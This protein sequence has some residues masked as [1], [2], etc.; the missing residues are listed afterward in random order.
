MKILLIPLFFSSFALSDTYIKN[1]VIT[2]SIIG[3]NFVSSEKEAFS[4]ASKN[5]T[6][7]KSF[8]KLSINLAGNI[9]IEKS[10]SPHIKL[11]SD[12]KILDKFSFKVLD[13]TL[14]LDTTASINTKA[15]INIVVYTS[16]FKELSVQG[17]ARLDITG[18]DLHR[19][20][21]LSSGTSRVTFVSGSI[22]NFSLNSRGTSKVNLKDIYVKNAVI[23]AKGTSKTEI[24]I[25]GNLSVDLSGIS[26][27]KYWG[28]PNIQKRTK[29]LAKLIKMK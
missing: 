17:T 21:I 23:T 28:N 18:F 26:K 5:I 22:E 6:L 8:T 9:R 13:D 16:S 14:Y 12:K 10:N 27:V 1:S 7:N 29:N 15:P 20:N 24:N 25:N 19:L 3:N 11:T 2:N 4:L